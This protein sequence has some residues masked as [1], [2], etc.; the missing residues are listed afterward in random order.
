MFRTCSGRRLVPVQSLQRGDREQ[1][2][3]TCASLDGPK[4]VGK[5][6]EKQRCHPTFKWGCRTNRISVWKLFFF[7]LDMAFIEICFWY[8]LING[9]R[10]TSLMKTWFSGSIPF[11]I[12]NRALIIWDWM[13]NIV[14]WKNAE[15]GNILIYSNIQDVSICINMSKFNVTWLYLKSVLLCFVSFAANCL[16]WTWCHRINH[17]IATTW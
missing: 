5:P 14:A 11:R 13:V 6:W 12:P 15:V 10:E 9:I 3:R 1:W 17:W 4:D 7:R 16:L 2:L 8:I